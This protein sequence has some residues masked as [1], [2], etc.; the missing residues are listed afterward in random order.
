MNDATEIWVR[1]HASFEAHMK[2][3]DHASQEVLER[4]AQKCLGLSHKLAFNSSNCIV[5]EEML[6]LAALEELKVYHKRTTPK[7]CDGPI[8]I[9]NYD[10]QGVVIDGNNRVNLWCERQDSGPFHAIIIEPDGNGT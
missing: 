5:R 2:I 6:R 3:T 4:I 10:G 9:I 8:I 1:I 7:R